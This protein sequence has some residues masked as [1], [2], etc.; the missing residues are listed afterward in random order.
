VI[1]SPCCPAIDVDPNRAKAQRSIRNCRKHQQG[2]RA[3]IYLA[4]LWLQMT[5]RC[6]LASEKL[7]S[8]LLAAQ[9]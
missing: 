3:I 8:A 1:R 9:Q 5:R 4:G 7:T 2:D 6:K